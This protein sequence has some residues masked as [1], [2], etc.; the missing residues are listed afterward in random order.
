MSRRASVVERTGPVFR[1]SK[2]E[3][4]YTLDDVE[5]PHVTAMLSACGYIDERWFTTEGRERGTM[6]HDLAASYDLGAIE[7]PAAVECIWKG[8]FLA[9]VQA[10]RQI[11]PR[12]QFVETAMVSL[13]YRFGGRIDRGG[14]VWGAK[15]VVELK[16]GKRH[17]ATP[18]QLALQAILVAPEWHL[19]PEAIIRYELDLKESGKCVL[20]EHKDRKDF[21]KAYEVI[22]ACTTTA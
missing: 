21:D 20:Y 4:V 5:L 9:Y 3:H 15:S 8:W 6:V 11:K 12:W 13:R 22:E 7:H 18:I 14:T 19:P 2:A 1:F 16:T 10:M 17:Q